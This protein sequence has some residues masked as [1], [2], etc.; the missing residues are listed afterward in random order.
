M[1][2]LTLSGILL[3]CLSACAVAPSASDE[4]ASLTQ[5]HAVE[6]HNVPFF[7]Q[8]DYFCGPSSLAMLLGHQGVRTT[9]TQLAE[10]VYV[11]EKKGSLQ[12][13]MLAAPRQFGLLAYQTEPTVQS[14]LEAIN[15]NHP[16]LVLLNLALPV[17]PQWHYALVIGY[18]PTTERIVLR[19]GKNKREELPLTTFVKLWAR[20]NNWGFV[21][22]KP[23][24]SIP[25]FASA[26]R[27]LNALI[28]LERT[29]SKNALLGYK[30]AKEAWPTEPWFDFGTG[31]IYFMAD[32][33]PEAEQAFSAAVSIYP[34]FAD[35]WNNLAEVQFKLG[36]QPEARSAVNKALSLGGAH[37]STY[38]ETAEKIN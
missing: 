15:A 20:S 34:D 10:F 21:A 3:C 36:R 22:I 13:E 18:E 17:A 27:Y 38:K 1:K 12:L 9:P 19:S 2:L 28:G 30:R 4:N 8:E 29:D 35:A 7:S 25:S 37:L 11:P 33:L 32:Q 26:Q 31:N 23:D 6:L 24:S 14:L 5:Q 16:V